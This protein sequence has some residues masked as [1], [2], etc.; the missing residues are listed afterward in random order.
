M[1]LD[2]RGEVILAKHLGSLRATEF[3]AAMDAAY[4]S[5]GS[6]TISARGRRLA[7]ILFGRTVGEEFCD[8]GD[9]GEI[10]YSVRIEQMLMDRIGSVDGLELHELIN[11]AYELTASVSGIWVV[12]GDA[13]DFD[14]GGSNCD[15]VRSDANGTGSEFIALNAAASSGAVGVLA[16]VQV[17]WTIVMTGTGGSLTGV[18]TGVPQTDPSYVFTYDITND[19]G[20][21]VISSDNVVVEFFS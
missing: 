19:A 3:I 17:G 10:Q 6:G 8:I 13:G 11:M 2:A 15:F 21:A 7:E 14:A 5:G 1:A 16:D 9:A 12:G 4:V 20:W 18:V